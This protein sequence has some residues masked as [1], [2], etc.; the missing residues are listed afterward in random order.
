MNFVGLIGSSAETRVLV[1]GNSRVDLAPHS[2]VV[3]M[4]NPSQD[5]VVYSRGSEEGAFENF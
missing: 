3:G 1:F 2:R 4:T 5:N